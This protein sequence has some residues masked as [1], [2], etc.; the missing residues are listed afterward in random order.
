MVCVR[1]NYKHGNGWALNF[2]DNDLTSVPKEFPALSLCYSGEMFG[3]CSWK[4]DRREHGG[5]LTRSFLSPRRRNCL[6]RSVYESRIRYP[7][8]QILRL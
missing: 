8:Y 1:L 6:W 2:V 5:V 4:L 3:V 7:A